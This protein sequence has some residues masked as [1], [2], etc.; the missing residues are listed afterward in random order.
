M[1]VRAVVPDR[2]RRVALHVHRNRD[3]EFHGGSGGR[4]VRGLRREVLRLAR[5]VAGQV[6]AAVVVETE[7]QLLEHGRAGR[8]RGGVV[9]VRVEPVRRRR[10]VR[11]ADARDLRPAAMANLAD[12][13]ARTLHVRRELVLLDA[14]LHER[15]GVAPYRVVL[16]GIELLEH[17]VRI[18]QQRVG[19]IAD[20]LRM[21]ADRERCGGAADQPFGADESRGCVHVEVL[22]GGGA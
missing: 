15:G 18:V 3:I 14:R 11:V 2:L 7:A 5:H 6:P 13:L 8:Q 9:D 22:G 4:A 16:A 1:P 17:G 20:G 10:R 21:R 19:R 12:R